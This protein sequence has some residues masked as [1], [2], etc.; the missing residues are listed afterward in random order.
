VTVFEGGGEVDWDKIEKDF[1]RRRA[2]NNDHDRTAM[3][4][5][6]EVEPKED[7]VAKPCTCHPDE[8]FDPCEQKYAYNDCAEAR[9]QRK[10]PC[11]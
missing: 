6:R 9:R 5:R 1:Q 10:A 3:E 11:Q 8:R 7:I 2:M 4:M